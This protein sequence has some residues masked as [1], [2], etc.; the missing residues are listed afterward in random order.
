VRDFLTCGSRNSVR[1]VTGFESVRKAQSKKSAESWSRT[2]STW[3]RRSALK[4]VAEQHGS[5][6]FEVA[7]SPAPES[8]QCSALAQGRLADF[9]NHAT[10]KII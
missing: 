5:M 2:K 10:E 8:T 1:K 9:L 7:R 6:L 4:T 3:R